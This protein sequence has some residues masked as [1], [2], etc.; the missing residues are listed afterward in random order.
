MFHSVLR[1]PICEI[2]ANTARH[3]RNRSIRWTAKDEKAEKMP[4]LSRTIGLLSVWFQGAS[5][6]ASQA[7][8]SGLKRKGLLSIFADH[9]SF[10]TGQRL[11]R[12]C[13]IG[14][15]YSNLYSERTRRALVNSIWRRLQSKHAPTGKLF[16]AMAAIFVWDKERIQ[17]EEIHRFAVSLQICVV[18]LFGS[19][20]YVFSV[21]L[22]NPFLCHFWRCGLEL[23]ALDAV[24]NV[25]AS[26]GKMAGQL[27]PGWEV[28]MEKRDFKVWRRPIP[29]SH[30]YEYRG[31]Q[32]STRTSSPM[33][34]TCLVLT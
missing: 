25:D 20:L 14:E 9:C 7:A 8:K 31:Q 24:K 6:D 11:R 2:G 21:V 10:V 28:V 23:K 32:T 33:N 13:Q 18:A 27:E 1:R 15:L 22:S 17:D 26:S 5:V 29:D 12:T 34:R 19:C 16:A 3:Q 4:W 30:L